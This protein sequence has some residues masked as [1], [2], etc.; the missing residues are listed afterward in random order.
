MSEGILNCITILDAI[1]QGELN[2]ARNLRDALRDI[3][4]Y[5]GTDFEVRYFRI[6]N[7]KDLHTAI[8]SITMESENNGLVPWLHLEGHGL[9]DECGF[10]TADGTFCSWNVLKEIITPLN[11]ATNLN[12][13][14][15]LA[16]CYGGSFTK[17]IT[18]IDRAPVFGVIGPTREITVGEVEVDF[19]AFY[20]TFFETHTLKQA[21]DA[22]NARSSRGL[23]YQTTATKF[24]CDVWAA[25]KT[26]ACSE[27]ELDIRARRMYRKAKKDASSPT[28]SIGQLKRRLKKEEKGLFEKYRD[29]YFM[30]D[31]NASNQS[32]FPVTYRDV[33]RHASRN[34]IVIE[35]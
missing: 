9:E 14:I 35:S 11:I 6:E 3:A 8:S 2:T 31:L 21:I 34:K 30:Y 19:P 12:T 5:G 15:V 10:A 27:K 26:N 32:R 23:Y 33:E 22:L 29:K 16:T 28:P 1:P 18:T 25:Y 20:K 7:Q 4:F 13:I 17:S 24:F